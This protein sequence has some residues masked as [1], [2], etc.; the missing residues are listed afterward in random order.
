M[1][2]SIEMGSPSGIMNYRQD[3]VN[4]SMISPTK[5]SKPFNTVDIESR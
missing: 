1:L 3:A 5:S 2:E 4:T